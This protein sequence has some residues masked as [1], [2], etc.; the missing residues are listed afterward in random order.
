MEK[1]INMPQYLFTEHS[2]QD[3]IQIRRFTVERWG[4]EQSIHYLRDLRK[5]LLLLSEMP[6]MGKDCFDDLGE[7]IYRFPYGS[8]IIYYLT[9]PNEKIVVVA[10]LHQSM[11]PAKH[12][13]SRLLCT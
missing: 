2:K 9:I 3:L 1:L 8:H 13:N 5:T 6:S 12:L 4:Y 7:N 10:I 11:V